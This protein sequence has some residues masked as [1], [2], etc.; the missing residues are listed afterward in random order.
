M[1]NIAVLSDSGCQIEINQYEDQGIFIAPLCITLEDH[2]Y[3]DQKEI[4]SIEVF[5]RMKNEGIDV[6]TS[7]PSTGVLVELIQKINN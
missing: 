6:K 1:K 3:L 4:S 2:T 7:Q 5:E